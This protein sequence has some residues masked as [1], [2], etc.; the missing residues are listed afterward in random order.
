MIRYHP[1][2]VERIRTSIRRSLNGEKPMC[3]DEFRVLH[4]DGEVRWVRQRGVVVRDPSGKAYRMAGSID[5]IT[6]RK[7]ADEA[8]RTSQTALRLSEERYS[9]AV[10]GSNEG[11]FDW[12]LLT[13]RVY[14]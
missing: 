9:L 3:E 11:I 5:D 2:D 1:E 10:E 14:V 6:D 7:R 4:R 8:L 13:D 12:D